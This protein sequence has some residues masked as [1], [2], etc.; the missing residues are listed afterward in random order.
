MAEFKVRNKATGEII[1]IRE[2]TPTSGTAPA[3]TGKTPTDVPYDRNDVSTGP[4][5]QNN[6]SLINRIPAANRELLRSIGTGEDAADAY[7]RGLNNPNKYSETF[8]DEALKK[9]YGAVKRDDVS[10]SKNPYLSAAKNTAIEI[11]GLG[12]SAAGLA[13]DIATN[14]KEALSIAIAERFPTLFKQI[15]PGLSEKI[16][17]IATKERKLGIPKFGS[18]EKPN[19]GNIQEMAKEAIR[20]SQALKA[21]LR[22]DKTAEMAQL[23]SNFTKINNGLDT[24]IDVLDGKIAPTD[25]NQLTIPKAADKATTVTRNKFWGYAKDLST[26][27]GA[28]YEKAI[29][30][31]KISTQKLYDAL[32]NAIDKDGF[33]IKP[34]AKWSKSQEAI[35][36]YA[37]KIKAEL[38]GVSQSTEVVFGPQGAVRSEVPTGQQTLN[39]SKVD[40]DIQSI[41]GIKKG[42]QYTS[43]DHILTLTREEVTNAI[44]EGSKR[45]SQVRR[46]FAPELQAKNELIKIAQPFNRSGEFDTSRGINFFSD[47]ASGKM[48]DPDQ[49][50][51]VDHIKGSKQLGSD[52]LKQLDSLSLERNSIKMN[53]LKLRDSQPGAFDRVNQK[54]LNLEKSVAKDDLMH[55]EVLDGM[56][57]VALQDEA[58]EAFKQTI[59][60]K[61]AIGAGVGAGGGAVVEAIKF[62]K[63]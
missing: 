29:A 58:R 3:P 18:L 38:P 21:K 28:A 57:Q 37:Q 63:D 61:A 40:K 35:Y 4:R 26:R 47:Y 56:K 43:G 54:Y 52:I 10:T 13:T 8:Q 60:K 59:I 19:S 24:K 39:L 49:L 7:M 41:L 55:Q 42:Q 48:S 31:E 11:G 32:Q 1:T 25:P 15:A 9:Y 53:Q 5:A 16:I 34:E 22:Q 51:L 6:P 50:R 46:T 30:G 27:F 36:N 12:A 33:A 44:G 14:P 2:K 20:D 45:V 62:L 23:R 17:Q